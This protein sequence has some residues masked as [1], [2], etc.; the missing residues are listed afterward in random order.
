MAEKIMDDVKY[1]IYRNL[2]IDDPYFNEEK[3]ICEFPVQDIFQFVHYAVEI[4]E[5]RKI[6]RQDGYE[7]NEEDCVEQKLPSESESE[8]SDY[9]EQD[10]EETAENNTRADHQAENAEDENWD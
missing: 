4:D 9:S 7:I 3:D 2:S 1:F 8:Q 6:I 10:A 5:M